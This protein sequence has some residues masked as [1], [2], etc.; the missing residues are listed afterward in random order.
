MSSLRTSILLDGKEAKE[1]IQQTAVITLETANCV[2]E[3]KRSSSPSLTAFSWLKPPY[4]EAAEG[5]AS[6]VALSI[7]SINK[8][9]YRLQ[10]SPRRNS[11]L[12][13]Q[14]QYL[15]EMEVHSFT[16]VDIRKAYVFLTPDRSAPYDLLSS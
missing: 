11:D 8:S 7:G 15:R 4:R 1:I 2:D 6:E 5:G 14:R 3:V 16:L 9:Q 10:F 12:V 13:L